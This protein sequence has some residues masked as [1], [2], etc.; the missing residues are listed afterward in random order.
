MHPVEMIKG[1][2]TFFIKTYPLLPTVAVIV[3]NLALHGIAS[4]PLC[5]KSLAKDVVFAFLTFDIWGLGML[6]R[7]KSPLGMAVNDKW[8]DILKWSLGALL[9]LHA[10]AWATCARSWGECFRHS[11]WLSLSLVR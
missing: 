11:S 8:S 4:V 3:L 10:Y 1:I 2:K 7:G 5:G 9:V 6:I